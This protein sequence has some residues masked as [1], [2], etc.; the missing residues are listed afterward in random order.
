MHISTPARAGGTRARPVSRTLG[1]LALVV[2]GL[3]V[4]CDLDS[5][6]PA[7]TPTI[8]RIAS[9]E[10]LGTRAG[11]FIQQGSA[12]RVRVTFTGAVDEI[13]GNSPYVPPVRDENFRALGPISWSPDGSRLAM[14]TTLAF[15]QSE[16]VV[17]NAD[18][19][20]AR[21]ASVNSQIILADPDWS[22]DGTRLVY[23]MSTMAHAQGVE[24]F[25]TNLATNHVQRLTH[26]RRYRPVGGSVR[27]ASTGSSILYGTV[28]SEGGA[29]LFESQSEIWRMD[30]ATGASTKLASVTGTVQGVARSGAWALVLKRKAYVDGD[31]DY[32]LVREAIGGG[33]S[34]TLIDGGRLAYAR[35]TNDDA[36]AMVVRNESPVRGESALHWYTLPTTGGTMA[37]VRGTNGATIA[38]N[39]FFMR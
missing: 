15:D 21:V 6:A 37:A 38:A 17:V 18:G 10:W 16:V 5:T 28:I 1:F 32:A 11:L 39:A 30:L 14:V 24:L 22:P 13:P 8:A 19:S 31:Y 27:F 3:T 2:P 7:S 35:L 9:T 4:G 25:T 12:E 23:A 26:D 33:T 29:P 36:R 20:N 34:T